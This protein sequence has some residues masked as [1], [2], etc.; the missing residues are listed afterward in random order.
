MKKIFFALALLVAPSLFATDYYVTYAGAGNGLSVATPTNLEEIMD[1]D[2]GLRVLQPGDTVHLLEDVYKASITGNTST[3]TLRG[4]CSGTAA[5]PITFKRYR[6]P[7][8]G[9][10]AHAV[11][12]C[13][14]ETVP[15]PPSGRFCVSD[16]ADT[17]GPNGDPPSPFHRS[18][19][20][21]DGL[22]VLNSSTETRITSHGKLV[23]TQ[24]VPEVTRHS[25]NN[26]LFSYNEVKVTNV[27]AVVTFNDFVNNNNT[28]CNTV[29]NGGGCL[30]GSW[31]VSG[32]SGPARPNM[33]LRLDGVTYT[34]ASLQSNTQ[35][36]L[37]T[38][39]PDHAAPISAYTPWE[40][41]DSGTDNTGRPYGTFS[42]DP[43]GTREDIQITVCDSDSHCYLRTN[44]THASSGAGGI[45]GHHPEGPKTDPVG[46]SE[47][48]IIMCANLGCRV[49]NSYF[50]DSNFQSFSAQTSGTER[51][52]GG[53]IYTSGN[54][55]IYNGWIGTIRSYAHGFYTH[56]LQPQSRSFNLGNLYVRNHNL[57]GQHYGSGEVGTYTIKDNI[58]FFNGHPPYNFQ[59]S[60]IWSD[61]NLNQGGSGVVMG[62][63]ASVP[64]SSCTSSTAVLTDEIFDHNFVAPNPTAYPYDLGFGTGSCGATVTRNYLITNGKPRHTR[65]KGNGSGNQTKVCNQPGVV[66]GTYEPLTVGSPTPGDMSLANVF[67]SNIPVSTPATEGAII[68]GPA[69]DLNQTFF[70]NNI[71]LSAIKTTDAT[72]TD[73][74]TLVLQDGDCKFYSPNQT[75]VA[76]KGIAAVHNPDSDST[77][78]VDLCSMGGFVGQ[79][80][81]LYYAE[82]PIPWGVCTPAVAWDTVGAG[83]ANCPGGNCQAIDACPYMVTVLAATPAGSILQ[84]GYTDHDGVTAYPKPPPIGPKVQAVSLENDFLVSNPTA[85][86]TATAT[87]TPTS[88]PTRTPT[89]TFTPSHTPTNTPTLT[90]TPTPAAGTP[91][92]TATFTPSNTPTVTPTFTPSHTPTN[93]RTPGA[94][95][96]G[97]ASID[98]QNCTLTAPMVRTTNANSGQPNV[99]LSS[100]TDNQGLAVCGFTIPV[101]GF[102]Y[103]FAKVEGSTSTEDSFFWNIC[104]NNGQ[105]CYNNE[106]IQPDCIASTGTTCSVIF[107]IREDR[108]PNDEPPCQLRIVSETW[109]WQPMNHRNGGGADICS[110]IG[111]RSA[112]NLAAGQYKFYVKARDSDAKLYYITLSTDPDIELGDIQP[113]PTPAPGTCRRLCRCNGKW[114]IVPAQCGVSFLGPCSPCPF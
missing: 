27:G 44:V 14:N 101:T 12:D 21:F 42:L 71:F 77:V 9:V 84:P 46:P 56:Q 55:T 107:D 80:W 104:D 82:C 17:D 18:Y 76:G 60:A 8:T 103:M 37:T 19:V 86:P 69:R 3:Y 61:Y 2:D 25:S 58:F 39:P 59:P 5:L 92:P 93:T 91:T 113:T 112:V 50:Q 87:N 45:E 100:P 95:G 53:D 11:I 72:G 22:H 105:N 108:D 26:S 73:C 1:C 10:E 54:I 94:G 23:F 65:R 31:L 36:T 48:G 98:V 114:G 110:G 106:T 7:A 28:F 33:F 52:Y 38:A 57:A 85:T 40:W 20:R 30:G 47:Y 102:Y 88:T 35:L 111:E 70:P 79:K 6:N 90:N 51:S 62:S 97:T 29:G 78:R 4:A 34:I 16:G 43:Y 13:G 24:G 68:G 63:E 81:Q 99:Y 67:M 41:N 66:C 49:T 89:R 96:N 32:T 74:G 75:G 83:E 64:A 15:D 109:H